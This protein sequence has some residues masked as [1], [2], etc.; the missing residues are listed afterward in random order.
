MPE[1]GTV[2]APNCLW[3]WAWDEDLQQTTLES[4]RHA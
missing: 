2:A 4:E 3:E 1:A